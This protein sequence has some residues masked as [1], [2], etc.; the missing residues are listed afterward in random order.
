MNLDLQCR[1][2]CDPDRGRV[3]FKYR[4]HGGVSWQTRWSDRLIAIRD[5]GAIGKACDAWYDR[6]IDCLRDVI[7]KG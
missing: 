3:V 6:D 4:R 5:I 2:I 1:T 7:W